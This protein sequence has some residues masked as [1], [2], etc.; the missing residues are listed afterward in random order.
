MLNDGFVNVGT[1]VWPVVGPITAL[2][3]MT[4]AFTVLGEALRDVMD[5]AYRP[6]RRGFFGLGRNDLDA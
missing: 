2:V 1:S 5:P 4:A 6:L 3:V